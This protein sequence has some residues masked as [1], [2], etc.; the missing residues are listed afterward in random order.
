MRRL[1]IKQ[2]SAFHAVVGRMK[3]EG[4]VDRYPPRT[5]R[6]TWEAEMCDA[7]NLCLILPALWLDCSH[8]GLPMQ[9]KIPPRTTIGEKAALS[10]TVLLK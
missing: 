8:I 2:L 3:M 10:A 9:E 6:D 4:R 7:P 1:V 5:P